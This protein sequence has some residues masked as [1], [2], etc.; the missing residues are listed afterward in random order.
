MFA[1]G[2][3]VHGSFSV[4]VNAQVVDLDS[5]K[6]LLVDLSVN[7]GSNSLGN[8]DVQGYVQ[9]TVN[10]KPGEKVRLTSN[11]KRQYL[12]R[13]GSNLKIYES[14]TP[15]LLPRRGTVELDVFV[16]P[17]LENGSVPF[18]GSNPPERFLLFK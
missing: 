9:L 14:E 8:M 4:N 1:E 18:V 15:L 12:T 3:G 17:S 7:S 16:N 2:V 10:G 13:P 6:K 5:G 11:L